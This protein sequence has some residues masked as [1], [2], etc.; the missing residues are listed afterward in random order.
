MQLGNELIGIEYATVP[1]YPMD[2]GQIAD[3]LQWVGIENDQIGQPA[4]RNS[5]NIIG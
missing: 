3:A 4:R 2:R 1:D 5:T